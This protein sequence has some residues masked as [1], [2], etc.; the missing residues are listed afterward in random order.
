MDIVLLAGLWLPAD[1]WDETA[2]HLQALGHRAQAVTLPGQDAAED[3]D[4]ARAAVLEDQIR[5]ARRAVDDLD[6]PLVV[7]HSAACTLAWILADQ[8]SADISGVALVG[9]FP[10]ADG[11]EYA[12]FFPCTDGVMPFPGWE[13]FA[14]ADSA[15]LSAEQKQEIAARAIPVPAGVAQARVRYTHPE[16]HDV[17]TWVVC[18]E[19]SPAEASAWIQDGDVPE[20]SRTEGVQ[21]VDINSGHWPMITRPGELARLLADIA[22]ACANTARH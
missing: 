7:G 22:E 12:A 14:G 18:P 5:V 21:L 19:F 11:E 3:P 9:G 4:R 17:P 15:D 16:R 20:L 1:V 2:H 6:V 13:P 10:S 8:R